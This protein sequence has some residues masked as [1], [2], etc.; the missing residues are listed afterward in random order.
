MVRVRIPV[1]L[2]WYPNG[3]GQRGGIVRVR[4]RFSFFI[5]HCQVWAPALS[6]FIRYSQLQVSELL[7]FIRYSQL[8]VTILK[9]QTI[10]SLRSGTMVCEFIK[11]HVQG[12]LRVRPRRSKVCSSL[13]QSTSRFYFAQDPRSIISLVGIGG[14]L[15]MIFTFPGFG[16]IA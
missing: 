13:H 12:M 6:F 7:F 16:N 3:L 11:V 5:R 8:Q 1:S 4:A 9:M 10:E 2:H 15:D 14:S